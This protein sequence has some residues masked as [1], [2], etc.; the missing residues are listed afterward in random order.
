MGELTQ[1][2]YFS[3]IAYMLHASY[4]LH[5][6]KEKNTVKSICCAYLL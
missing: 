6:N 3:G 4:M 2:Y 1:K 5:I